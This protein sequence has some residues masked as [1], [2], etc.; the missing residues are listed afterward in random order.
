[1]KKQINSINPISAFFLDPTSKKFIEIF[2]YLK[3]KKEIN[4]EVYQGDIEKTLNTIKFDHKN[5]QSFLEELWVEFSHFDFNGMILESIDFSNPEKD[6][7]V[8]I[9][10]ELKKEISEALGQYIKASEEIRGGNLLGKNNKLLRSFDFFQIVPRI[11]KKKIFDDIS[12]K[13]LQIIDD[14]ALKFSSILTRLLTEEDNDQLKYYDNQAHYCS[15]RVDFPQDGMSLISVFIFKCIFDGL[16]KEESSLETI[17]KVDFIFQC[18]VFKLLLGKHHHKTLCQEYFNKILHKQSLKKDLLIF[19]NSY[20]NFLDEDDYSLYFCQ[21]T[22]FSSWLFHTVPQAALTIFLRELL[23]IYHEYDDRSDDENWFL[24]YCFVLAVQINGDFSHGM[25]NEYLIVSYAEESKEEL[26]WLLKA[27][28]LLMGSD[29]S[30]GFKDEPENIQLNK[31][32]YVPPSISFKILTGAYSEIDW[33]FRE[34]GLEG[35]ITAFNKNIIGNYLIRNATNQSN[36]FAVNPFPKGFSGLDALEY[37]KFFADDE[38]YFDLDTLTNSPYCI[39]LFLQGYA[40]YFSYD[41]QKFSHYSK[42]TDLTLLKQNGLENYSPTCF[43]VNFLN[44]LI[45][46]AARNNGES[47]SDKKIHFNI[48]SFK[49]HYEFL[50]SDSEYKSE[51]HIFHMLLNTDL[52]SDE[53]IEKNYGVLEQQCLISIM[54]SVDSAEKKKNINSNVTYLSDDLHWIKLISDDCYKIMASIREEINS[55]EKSNNE[56]ESIGIIARLR[57]VAEEL[58]PTVIESLINFIKKHKHI[59]DKYFSRNNNFN[60]YGIQSFSYL[61]DTTHKMNTLD[62]NSFK[63][64]L[65]EQSHIDCVRRIRDFDKQ[66]VRDFLRQTSSLNSGSH[67][68][69]RPKEVMSIYEFISKEKYFGKIIDIS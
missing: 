26:E 67:N 12:Q 8:E 11:L 24:N 4:W 61:V 25:K 7:H 52:I 35:K 22:N 30:A 16:E 64:T 68:N 48:K 5:Y 18:M 36:D 21:L 46:Q 60:S 10:P 33:Y 20:A 31:A 69:L 32:L 40:D 37:I 42:I 44:M 28:N 13:H 17:Q 45:D 59:K 23:A 53:L 34:I 57:S 54:K 41:I 56:G 9:K 29:T 66:L 19:D 49:S 38:P 63:D 39:P 51:L 2:A 58:R 62:F 3:L 43:V 47:K 15:D 55:K 14:K 1:M 6:G 50:K 65:S 27:F